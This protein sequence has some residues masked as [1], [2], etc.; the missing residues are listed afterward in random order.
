[1]NSS[2]KLI[3]ITSLERSGSTLL[4]VTLGRHQQLISF[5]EVARVLLPHDGKGMLGVIDRPCSCGKTVSTCPFWGTVTARIQN[6]ETSLSLRDRY[7]IF[8]ECFEQC[9][10]NESIPVDSSKFIDALDAV[11]TIDHLD[12]RVLFTIRDVRGWMSSSRK[13]SLRKRELPYNLILS[14]KILAWW[15]PYLRYNVLR[16]L[17]F[18]LPV[19]W[20]IRNVRLMRYLFTNKIST[21]QLSYEQLNF[22]TRKTL[23]NIYNFLNINSTIDN[24]YPVTHIVRGNRMAFGNNNLEIHYDGSWLC[25]LL[26]QYE[27]MALPFVMAKNKKW[28]YEKWH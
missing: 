15:K 24:S 6:N 22:D 11:Q 10:G 1:M 4:D 20:Y 12:L 7:I 5:G 25:D 26:S 9:Y 23:I 2:R 28:V 21:L 18:W 14:S 17:P 19:E 27:A 13:A 3:F 8:L 16:K